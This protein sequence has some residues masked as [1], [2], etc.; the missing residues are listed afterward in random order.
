M[1]DK[2]SQNPKVFTLKNSKGMQ[3]EVMDWGATLHSIKV[4]VGDGKLREVLIGPKDA[5]DYASQ[6]CY[7][8]ATIGRYANRI[9][10][11]TFEA[12]GTTYTVDA[13]GKPVALHGGVEG[14]DK[15]RFSLVEA[16]DTKLVLKL[17]SKDGDQGFPGN[18]ELTVTFTITEENELK[19][20]YLGTCDKECPAC[21]TN[22]SYFNLNGYHSS[23]L[24][25]ECKLNSTELLVLNDRAVPT[26][27][28]FDVVKHN[29]ADGS[30]NNFN[31][32]NFKPFAKGKD[33]SIFKDDP[34][35]E[36]SRAYDHPYI[37]TKGSAPTTPCATVRSEAVDNVVVELNV[38]TD[39]P[40]FQLYTGNFINADSDTKAIGRDDGKEYTFFEGFC[41]EPEFFP[42]APH[43]PQFK[44]L[45]PVVSPNS[46]LDRFISYKFVTIKK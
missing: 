30:P 42:D 9:D 6:P 12:N 4:P 18:F 28:V 44:D 3:V 16:T 45:N 29:K 22:H 34:N 20:H 36:F 32:T 27:E 37:I 14:F 10:K 38:Y 40:A 15:R 39:Y 1:S 23:I 43:L 41:I 8:G 17:L 26:G 5:A 13:G 46:N 2:Y 11:C 31:F 7:M 25:H 33:S 35:M 19:M 24:D 21:I